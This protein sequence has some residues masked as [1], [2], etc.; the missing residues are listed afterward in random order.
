MTVSVPERQ[1]LAPAAMHLSIAL[2]GR[3]AFRSGN[4]IA[5]PLQSGTYHDAALQLQSHC[6]TARWV[7]IITDSAF[8]E[9]A[10]RRQGNRPVET[11]A[12]SLRSELPLPV[13]ENEYAP[14]L[15]R[16]VL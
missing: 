6:C 10:L 5:A 7:I 8:S 15:W 11:A 1:S 3:C 9:D 12:A 4:Q 13:A 2:C 14:A 16:A